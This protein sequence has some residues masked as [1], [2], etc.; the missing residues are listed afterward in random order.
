VT[1]TNVS[2]GHLEPVGTAHADGGVGSVSGH[3][4]RAKIEA[5]QKHLSAIDQVWPD[6]SVSL[7]GSWRMRLPVAAKMALVTAG[8]IGAAPGL[9]TPPH[10]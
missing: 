1:S 4:P 9:P 10:F 8:A 6:M 3:S 5:R 2:K 7:I